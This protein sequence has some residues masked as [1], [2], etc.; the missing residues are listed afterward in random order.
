MANGTCSRRQKSTTAFTL[1]ELLLTVSLMLMLAGAVILNLGSLDSNA[2]LEEGASQV[3]TLFRYA[4]AQAA[5]TGRQV[6]IVFS[7]SEPAI[8]GMASSTNQ[9]PALAST[10]SGVQVLWEPDPVAAPGRFEAL[11]GVE[12]LLEQVNDLVKVREVGQPGMVPSQGADLDMDA[13]LPMSQNA[14]TNGMPSMDTAAT[15]STP[16]LT[17]Y[18]DG[19]SDSMEV[20]L[21]AA[22]GEDKRLAAV[23]LLGLSGASRHR[24]IT[25]ADDSVWPSGEQAQA[26]PGLGR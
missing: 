6:R 15:T 25:R 7:S 17:C 3:E 24:L 2:R 11:P 12:L 18:P 13:M 4:R 8:G 22:G 5:D 26:D 23:T 14:D 10:N 19:S 20:I 1:V 9:S 16:P 21:T